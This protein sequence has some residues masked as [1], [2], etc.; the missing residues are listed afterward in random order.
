MWGVTMENNFN[1][2]SKRDRILTVATDLF[3]KHGLSK[4]T[5]NMIIDQSR[6]SRGTVYKY[7]SDKNE[8]Y[9]TIHLNILQEQYRSLKNCIHNENTD[10]KEKVHEIIKIRLKRYTKTNN[11]FY[12]EKVVFSK[13]NQVIIDD[14]FIKLKQIRVDFFELGKKEKCIRESINISLFSLFFNIIQRG[15]MMEYNNI[16]SL[17]STDQKKL[18]ELLYAEFLLENKK[19]VNFNFTEI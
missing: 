14:L 8:I 12:E 18:F 16:L 11:M 6:I 9:E 19:N 15:V 13:E 4:T 7:F 2:E 5:M 1:K 10:F 3:N 17:D